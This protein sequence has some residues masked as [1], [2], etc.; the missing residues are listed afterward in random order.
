MRFIQLRISNKR[1]GKV[2]CDVFSNCHICEEFFPTDESNS[3]F[4]KPTCRPC[5]E[6]QFEEWEARKW[7]CVL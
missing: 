1:G 5:A 7:S 6:K 2:M 4:D 3:S